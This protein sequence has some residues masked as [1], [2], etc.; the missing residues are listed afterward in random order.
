M[1][2]C[3]HIGLQQLVNAVRCVQSLPLRKPR[4]I[5]RKVTKRNAEVWKVDAIK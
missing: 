3:P 1:Q 4:L 2:G 5:L